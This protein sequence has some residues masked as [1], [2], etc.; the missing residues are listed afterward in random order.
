MKKVT[1]AVKSEL[2][3]NRINSLAVLPKQVRD[4]VLHYIETGNIGKSA[5]RAGYKNV[6]SGTVLL[7][8]KKVKRAVRD[9]VALECE[10]FDANED[11]IIKALTLI[12]NANMSDYITWDKYSRVKLIPKD[13]LS[14][15]QLYAIDEISE[16]ANGAVKVKIKDKLKALES[17]AK[18]RGM[19]TEKKE[20]TVHDDHFSHLSYDYDTDKLSVDELLQL[21]VLLEKAKVQSVKTDEN[22]S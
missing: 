9:C 16:A 5:I 4:F 14:P 2:D 17:L 12:V 21:R 20:I 13:Q 19:F 8:K 10:R 22:I 3:L 15:E 6:N 7:K 18:I 1:I 11:S